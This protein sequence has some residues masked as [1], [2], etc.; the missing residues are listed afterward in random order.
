MK[1]RRRALIFHHTG[2]ENESPEKVASKV[3]QHLQAV[4][5]DLKL[6]L[7]LMSRDRELLDRYPGEALTFPEARSR[8]GDSI[9]YFPLSPSLGLKPSVPLLLRLRLRRATLICDYHGDFREELLNVAR[10]REMGLFLYSVPS[11]VLAP[12]LLSWHE[13]IVLH[14]RYLERILRRRYRLRPRTVV[15][16]NGIEAGVIGRRYEKVEL[17]GEFNIFFHGRHAREKGVDL[18]LEALAGAEAALRKKVHLYIAGRGPLTASLKREAAAGGIGEQ[19]HFV[20]YPPI[21]E[22]YSYMQS[23]Q[24]MFY[25]SRYDNFPVAVLEALAVAECPV[26]FSEHMGLADRAGEELRRGIVPLS[27]SSL[28]KRIRWVVEGTLDARERV[29]VQRREAGLYTWEKVIREYVDFFN[30]LA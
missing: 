25:P 30:T 12:L 24:M 29:R 19:V 14:S 2:A 22:V 23:A 9:F 28:R 11:A 13:H 5:G 10:N 1:G 17:E 20:G 3:W 21:E 16:P 8:A 26:F 15:I 18:L 27:A 7:R 6:E 4:K